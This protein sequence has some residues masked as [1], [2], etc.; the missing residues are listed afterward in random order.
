M[1][2]RDKTVALLW[3]RF[4]VPV[5]MSCGGKTQ[6]SISYFQSPSFPVP[7]EKQL[8]CNLVV[9]LRR[10]TSQVLLEFEAFELRPPLNGDCIDDRF[11]VTG[12]NVNSG[13]PVICG[14][15]TG[16]HSETI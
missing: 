14:I 10:D 13:V 2:S 12:Q 3:S 8:D 11:I 1:K 6:Q 7:Y 15:N 9:D 4:L 5:Q 16:Q